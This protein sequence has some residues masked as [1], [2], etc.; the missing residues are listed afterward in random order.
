[1]SANRSPKPWLK[2]CISLV[3]G[4]VFPHGFVLTKLIYSSQ[5]K[6]SSLGRTVVLVSCRQSINQEIIKRLKHGGKSRTFGNVAI[7]FSVSRISA[8][9]HMVFPGEKPE[10]PGEGQA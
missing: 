10:G 5:G 3:K 7:G 6:T 1:M 9:V 2:L 4:K 8:E